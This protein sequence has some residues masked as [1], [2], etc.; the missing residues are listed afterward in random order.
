MYPPR[1]RR[2]DLVDDEL[3]LADL[4]YQRAPTAPTGYAPGYG[5]AEAGYGPGGVQN[6][7]YRPGTPATPGQ[8]P[9]VQDPWGR[10]PG[11][12]DYGKR[13]GTEPS[14]PKGAGGTT[15]PGTPGTGFTPTAG[16]G[17]SGYAYGGFDFNQDAANR[18]T[19]KSAKYAFADA[20]RE[21]GEAGAGTMWHTKEGAAR[22]AEQYLK[23]KLEAAGYQVLE[24]RGEKMRIVTREDREAGNTEGSWVDWVIGADGPNPQLAWQVESGTGASGTPTSAVVTPNTPTPGVSTTQPVPAASAGARDA[25]VDPTSDPSLLDLAY[26]Y[27]PNPRG[28]R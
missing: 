4:A 24:I 19:A 21:A 1:P 8:R 28:G 10:A 7:A 12:P 14:G 13:P 18:D 23:P 25:L 27:G 22:F 9:A 5:S 3:S 17:Y 2:R 16:T 11:S 6:P 26:L 20:T 15:A